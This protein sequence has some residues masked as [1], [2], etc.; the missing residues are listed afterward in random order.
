MASPA[1]PPKNLS[2]KGR[3][4]TPSKKR[5]LRLRTL[6]EAQ[7]T[8]KVLTDIEPADQYKALK[9]EYHAFEEMLAKNAE[10]VALQQMQSRNQ[11]RK[12]GEMF[13]SPGP[14]KHAGITTRGIS[15]R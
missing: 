1:T 14:R 12:I 7:T 9:S 15:R 8:Q 10:E 13:I 5:R 2:A 6:I 4:L 3:D 11:L